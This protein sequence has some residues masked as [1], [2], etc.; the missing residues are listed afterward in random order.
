MADRS[1]Q[2]KTKK[3]D[4][5]GILIT[6]ALAVSSSWI[7]Y[8]R[9]MIDHDLPLPNAMPAKRETYFSK[10]YGKMC[11]YIER[12]AEG[13]PLV[14]LHSINAA[15]SSYEMRPLFEYYRT[16]RPVYALDWPGYGFSERTPR[17]YSPLFF[18]N[19]LV[20]FIATQVGEPA[21][22]VA[23]S[24][25]GEFAARSAFSRPDL[26]RSLVLISP[27][28][29]SIRPGDTSL[30]SPATG[31]SNFAYNALSFP[32][33]GQA[34]FDLIASRRS[35]DFFLK[36]I[37]V[38]TI[39]PG[40]ADYSYLT[41]HQAGA[42]HVP[43]HFLSGKLFSPNIVKAVYQQLQ[44]PTLAIYDKDA[45][46]TFER[47][48]QVLEQNPNWQSQQIAPTRG[49]PHFEKLPETVAALDAFW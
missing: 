8:S 1:L 17:A 13:R 48:P 36:Q 7:M 2:S 10:P 18:E 26:I 19:T 3:R 16:K 21:D 23:L 40:L 39:A 38:G 47:L 34:L 49:M 33:W 11:Y 46:V 9:F 12:K 24:L 25:G 20:E 15:A 43:L 45:Y 22:V 31:G 44:V 6:G 32:L 28:G 29:L 5:L 27:N 30:E 37:F 4:P 42:H 14:L 35:I 41:A